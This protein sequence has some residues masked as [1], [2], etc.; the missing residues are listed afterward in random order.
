MNRSCYISP[1]IY[2]Q[3]CCHENKTN[4]QLMNMGDFPCFYNTFTDAVG[5]KHCCILL[6]PISLFSLSS[7]KRFFYVFLVFTETSLARLE[8]CIEITEL[9]KLIVLLFEQTQG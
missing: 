5:V 2:V 7:V 6:S 4:A 3:R 8:I 9:L 1:N